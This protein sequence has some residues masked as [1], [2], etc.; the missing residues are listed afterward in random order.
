MEARPKRRAS[1]KRVFPTEGEGHHVAAL[2][3]LS[4][5]PRGRSDGAEAGPVRD[6]G[7]QVQ[8]WSKDS[9]KGMWVSFFSL[10]IFNQVGN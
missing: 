7:S 9:P 1:S 3:P 5:K 8:T 4:L 6:R 2:R 10:G